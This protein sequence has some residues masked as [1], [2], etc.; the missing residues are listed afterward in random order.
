MK[1][2]L[3]LMRV[4]H[5]LKNV[6]IFVPIFFANELFEFDLW[7]NSI[8]GFFA[9][10]FAASFVYVINDIEDIDNDRRH[11]IKK[12][13]PLAAG[14]ISIINAKKLA[15][16]LLLASIT[17]VALSGMVYAIVVDIIY[18]IL[19]FFYSKWLKNVEIVDVFC[20]AIFYVIRIAF[21]GALTSIVI[22][23]Y[24][25]LTV[26]VLALYLG[27]SKRRNEYK[28][29]GVEKRLVLSK[30]SL[31]Y[32]E[33]SMNTFFILTIVFYA[34]WCEY[35]RNYYEKNFVISVPVVI[36]VLLRY[37]FDVEHSDNDDPV[38][39]VLTDKKLI[40]LIIGYAMM[41]LYFFYIR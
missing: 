6:L 40:A 14:T 1:A 24:L 26:F 21:G 13:R 33:K 37:N 27:F 4:S 3:K 18:I 16:I 28:A 12:N 20:L 29:E 15:V 32:L 39:I 19:N 36:L 8:L 31:N 25:Y 35:M 34:S 2:Y 41:M 10:S 11:T 9:F 23:D 5:Y 38:D 22:S 30:Y 17:L 7:R